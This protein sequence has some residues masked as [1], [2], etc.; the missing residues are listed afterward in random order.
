[1]RGDLNMKIEPTF[2][3]KA[4]NYG[5]NSR[6]T[7]R[8]IMI[9]FEISAET[10]VDTLDNYFSVDD[11]EDIRE[12][13]AKEF[14]INIIEEALDPESLLDKIPDAEVK[15]MVK[16]AGVS[17]SGKESRD[18]LTGMVKALASIDEAFTRTLAKHQ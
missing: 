5:S 14:D 2:T 4:E 8:D 13:V 6:R 16:D 10:L 9:E 17:L 12:Y 7:L 3:A 1:M 15:K 11:I 18:E